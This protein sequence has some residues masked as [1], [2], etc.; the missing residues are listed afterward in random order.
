MCNPSDGLTHLPSN[1]SIYIVGYRYMHSY[2]L[3][4]LENSNKFYC[5]SFVSKAKE[6]KNI[7]N[8]VSQNL[9]FPIA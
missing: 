7:K 4:L 2:R 6:R 3:Y 8:D 5:I 9:H 1:L